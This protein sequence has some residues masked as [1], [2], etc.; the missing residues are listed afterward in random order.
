MNKVEFVSGVINGAF[1]GPTMVAETFSEAE[2]TVEYDAYRVSFGD[3][4]PMKSDNTLAR[5]GFVNALLVKEKA[6]WKREMEGLEKGAPE[7]IECAELVKEVRGQVEKFKSAI[8]LAGH[9]TP[10]EKVVAQI[11]ESIEGPVMVP[12]EG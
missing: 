6:Y 1:A 12:V 8:R 7:M 5:Q 4:S 10:V 9:A 3:R 11:A 2:L